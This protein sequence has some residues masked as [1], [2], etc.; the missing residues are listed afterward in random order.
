MKR[1]EYKERASNLLNKLFDVEDEFSKL[2]RDYYDAHPEEKGDK[3]TDFYKE[4]MVMIDTYERG[5][6]SIKYHLDEP[7]SIQRL[8]VGN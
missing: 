4:M 7:D 3:N 2:I 8:P 1:K 5:V 6:D